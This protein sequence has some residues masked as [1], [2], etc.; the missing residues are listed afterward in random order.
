MFQLSQI[1]AIPKGDK[2][3]PVHDVIGPRPMSRDQKEQ[4]AF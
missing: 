3:S 4:N 1:C 2:Y